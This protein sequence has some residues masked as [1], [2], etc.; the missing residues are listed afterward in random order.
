MGVRLHLREGVDPMTPD[1][2]VA[3]VMIVGAVVVLILGTV[4]AAAREMPTPPPLTGDEPAAWWD[5]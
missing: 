2:W 3:A 1:Q 4:Q 5:Q